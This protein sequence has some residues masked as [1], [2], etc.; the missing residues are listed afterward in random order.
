[1]TRFHLHWILLLI[2]L[3]SGEELWAQTA[4]TTW[5]QTDA[6]GQKQGHWK[7]YD[8]DGNMIYRGYFKDGKPVGRMERYYADGT[9]RAEL[10]YP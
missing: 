7:K 2:F 6:L 10:T 5:N 9:R 3:I 1:M 4:D 8:P